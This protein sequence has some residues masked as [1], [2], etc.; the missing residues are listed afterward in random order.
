MYQFIRENGGFNNFTIENIYDLNDGELKFEKEQE[1]IDLYNPS[2]N[3]R[4][5][6]GFDMVEYIKQYD[7]MNSL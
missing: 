3:D 4:R 6:F 5:A 7:Y 2:L 1:Y